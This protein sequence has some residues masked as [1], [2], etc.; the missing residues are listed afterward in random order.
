M[1]HGHESEDLI[2]LKC[3]FSQPDRFVQSNPNPVSIG[4]ASVVDNFIL[5]FM[6]KSKGPQIARTSLGLEELL[7]PTSRLTELQYQDQEVST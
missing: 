4:L 3:Q 1:Y 7:E 6:W 2:L 5:K